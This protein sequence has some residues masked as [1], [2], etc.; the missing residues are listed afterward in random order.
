MGFRPLI[1]HILLAAGVAVASACGPAPSPAFPAGL[2]IEEHAL[3][4]APT[5]DPL[6]F[7]PVESSMDTILARHAVER[8]NG[9]P[10]NSLLQDGHFS[11]RTTINAETLVASENYGSD[12]ASSWVTVMHNGQ[13][14][15]RVDTGMGSPVTPL[16]GL[17][18]YADHWV[19]ETAY[20]THDSIGGRLSRDGRALNT[21][22][23][24]E[25]AFDFQLLKGRPFYFF[26]KDGKIGFSYDGEDVPAGYDELPHYGCCSDAETN[27]RAAQNMVAFFARRGGA[28][29]YIEIGVFN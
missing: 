2:T 22:L 3:H 18:A 28:W 20:I 15:Y 10:D 7:R 8:A 9:F 5:L 26:K 29:Y 23:G 11:L 12:S 6:A 1:A 21:S 13:E 4:E 25:D 17:W 16:R 19:L 14:V 27:P 24:Y